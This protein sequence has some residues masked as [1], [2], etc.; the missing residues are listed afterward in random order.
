ELPKYKDL[1]TSGPAH[2]PIFKVS[3]NI[4]KSKS[5]IGEGSSKRNAEQKAAQSLLDSLDNE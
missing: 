4:K 2:K 1:S 3:V 5:F